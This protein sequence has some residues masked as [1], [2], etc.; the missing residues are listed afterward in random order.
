MSDRLTRPLQNHVIPAKAGRLRDKTSIQ[1]G[2]NTGMSHRCYRHL[3]PMK[4]LQ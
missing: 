1:R 2:R 4:S 3:V